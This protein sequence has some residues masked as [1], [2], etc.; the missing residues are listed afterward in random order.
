MF[1]NGLAQMSAYTRRLVNSPSAMNF[2][3]SADNNV[4]CDMGVIHKSRLLFF[5]F[6][7][8]L[9]PGADEE[10]CITQNFTQ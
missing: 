1:C 10:T 5:F 3:P 2:T 6:S 7:L 4:C 8:S 9:L